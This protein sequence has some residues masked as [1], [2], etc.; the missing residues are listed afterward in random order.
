MPVSKNKEILDELSFREFG[1]V[2]LPSLVR[3]KARKLA[4]ESDISSR[5]ALD[6]ILQATPLTSKK[7][8]T[9]K[10][11]QKDYMKALKNNKVFYSR[12]IKHSV[13]KDIMQKT[14]FWYSH[15]S[16]RKVPVPNF[17]ERVAYEE[18]LGIHIKFGRNNFLIDK[19]VRAV[20]RAS[21]ECV[22]ENDRH[23]ELYSC[24]RHKLTK[25][26]FSSYKCDYYPIKDDGH[27][28]FGVHSIDT[29]RFIKLV[30]ELVFDR[31]TPDPN[32]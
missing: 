4:R 14:A 1:V 26:V 10:E 8:R 19:A 13:A 15:P 28:V 32:A 24:A 7:T 29:N 12:A 27:M 6:I 9:K 31:K 2:D 23:N 20:V 17:S 30:Y 11:A 22:G 25:C 16:G 21:V 18:G 5:E 3:G